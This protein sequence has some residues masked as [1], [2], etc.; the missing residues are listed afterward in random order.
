MAKD[1]FI[2][3][4]YQKELYSLVEVDLGSF[5][6]LMYT[7]RSSNRIVENK[8]VFTDVLKIDS[9][10]AKTYSIKKNGKSEY[11]YIAINSLSCKT[12]VSINDGQT[13]ETKGTSKNHLIELVDYGTTKKSYIVKYL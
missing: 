12:S 4:N 13:T 7:S 5:Y 1:T 11:F 9:K 6:N 2:E 3:A 10:E 8:R